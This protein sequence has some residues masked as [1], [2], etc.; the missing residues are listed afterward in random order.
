M[1]DANQ[2]PGLDIDGLLS[3]MA[4]VGA[5]DLHLTV[6][7]PPVFRIEGRLVARHD[8]A[9]LTPQDVEAVFRQ[10]ATDAQRAAFARDLELDFAHSL[11][12]VA[13]FRVNALQQ[14]GSLSLAFRLVPFATPTI[15]GL[16]LPAVCKSL[17]TKP[18][19]LI[20]ITGAAGNGKSTTLAAMLHHLNETEERNVITIEDPIEFLFRNEKCIIRQREVG[21]DT[22]SFH[23]ALVHALRHDPDVIVIG[24]MRDLPTIRTA[25]TAAETGH[26]VIGTMHAVEAA[27]AVD[28]V[29]DL[30]PAEQQPQVR[31]QFSQVLEAVL[32]QMLLPRIGGGRIAA[33]EILLATQLIR[34]FIREGKIADILTNLEQG[35]QEGKQSMDQALAD[36]IKRGL[37]AKD[38]ALMNSSHPA[39]QLELLGAA[40]RGTG[41]ARGE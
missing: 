38:D 12:G 33:F 25:L 13:R 17:V 8:L 29:I 37:V 11:P 39:H 15:D 5:S 4:G 34:R 40:A 1:S 16:G 19:G 24:E 3:Q 18:R 9:A 21:Y 31:L 26:L 14:R 20:L 27:Q 30:F 35:A 10:I 22:Q 2:V 7:S 23:G 28:R 41:R 32:A 6:P 36:L